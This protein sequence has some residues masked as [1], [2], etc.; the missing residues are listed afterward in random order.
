M[1]L[2]IKIRYATFNQDNSCFVCTMGNEFSVWNCDNMKKRFTTDFEKP[3]GKAVV[4]Y[5]TNIALISGGGLPTNTVAYVSPNSFCIWDDRKKKVVAESRYSDV[6][7][8]LKLLNQ[9]L[10]VTIKNMIYIYDLNSIQIINEFETS[11]NPSG[12]CSARDGSNGEPVIA[13]LGADVGEV[14]IYHLSGARLI[15]IKAHNN[16]IV[17][18][19]LNRDGSLLATAS[20]KGTIIRVFNTHSGAVKYEFRRG[21]WSSQ[22]NNLSFNHNSTL[23]CVRNKKCTIHV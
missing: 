12:L 15:P 1:S 20:S 14:K 2:S 10:V 17:C 6:I 9:H 21:M 23:L 18:M 8:E 7:I 11:N 22:I 4:L 19:S 3:I 5:K 16:D 13:F